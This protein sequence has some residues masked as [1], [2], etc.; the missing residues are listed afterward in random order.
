[1]EDLMGEHKHTPGP[2]VNIG[3]GRVHGTP[4]YLGGK[5]YGDGEEWQGV[6]ANSIQEVCV[7]FPASVYEYS[8][9]DKTFPVRKDVQD[10]W[11]ERNKA[12]LNLICAAPDLLAALEAVELARH[13][14][15]PD[16]W[17]RATRLTD[18]ALAKAKQPT[19]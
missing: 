14:D 2:W 7:S 5:G 12:N 4:A 3:N 10:R 17:L 13:T 16:D 8:K 19:E 1:M 11:R 9:G 15:T 6:P 18:V